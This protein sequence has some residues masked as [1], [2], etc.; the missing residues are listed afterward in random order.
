MRSYNMLSKV[1]IIFLLSALVACNP[2][3]EKATP[4]PVVELDVVDSDLA[5]QFSDGEDHNVVGSLTLEVQRDMVSGK[6]NVYAMASFHEPVAK[7]VLFEKVGTRVLSKNVYQPKPIDQPCGI[8]GFP[9]CATP[10]AE[11]PIAPIPTPPAPQPPGTNPDQPC[12]IPGFPDCATH[13]LT[14]INKEFP[15]KISQEEQ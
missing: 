9:D 12:G 13:Q 10:P 14:L 2:L 15:K 7:N 11:P 1:G 4:P 3:K 6:T 5:Q 8:P